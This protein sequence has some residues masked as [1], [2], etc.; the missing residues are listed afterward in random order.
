MEDIKLIHAD[1]TDSTN[2]MLR[3]YAGEEGRL[4][5]VATAA[6]QTAGRGQGSNTWESERGANLLVS[7]RLHPRALPAARQYALT[8]A[9]ALAVR[10]TVARH[11]GQASIKWPNDIYVGDSKISGTLSECDICGAAIKTCTL[12]MG[13]NVN[14]RRFT[15]D[16]PNP[17]SLIQLTGRATPLDSLLHELLD[18][19]KAYASMADSG[20]YDRLHSLYLAHLYR[21]EGLHAYRD[22][23]G[24]FMATTVTV[25]PEGL[26]VLQ[27]TDGRQSEYEFKEV[28]FIIDNK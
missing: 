16:A 18:S 4:M 10:D 26:L 20:Q 3:E 8:E 2:R 24:S 6:Y 11:A 1:E 19:L 17:V 28:K 5:T 21:R 9:G 23:A 27:R 22:A 15:G 14:Q 12:G 7:V 13:I 25:R